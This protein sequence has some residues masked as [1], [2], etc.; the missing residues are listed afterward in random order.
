MSVRRPRSRAPG[1]FP[2]SRSDHGSGAIH[3]ALFLG[4]TPVVL[5]SIVLI[6]SLLAEDPTSVGPGLEQGPVVLQAPSVGGQPTPPEARDGASNLRQPAPPRPDPSWSLRVLD[7]AGAAIAGATV[8][9]IDRGEVKGR[10]TADDQ[11]WVRQA[12]ES[13]LG[14]SE[15]VLALAEGFAPGL[16]RGSGGGEALVLHRAAAIEVSVSSTAGAPIAGLPIAALQSRSGGLPS[17][18]YDHLA[19]NGIP[20]ELYDV[21]TLGAGPPALDQPGAEAALQELSRTLLAL[22]GTLGSVP[23]DSPLAWAL[24]RKT[25][26]AGVS[27]F[28][29][30][31]LGLNAPRSGVVRSASP[32]RTTRSCGTRKPCQHVVSGPPPSPP[33][34][35][36]APPPPPPAGELVG[37][38]PS[39]AALEGAAPSLCEREP[40]P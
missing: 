13:P 16:A 6:L 31:P 24:A 33:P 34:P 28:A 17:R 22:E 10:A 4:L 38:L 5:L 15:H 14:R 21:T 8:L 11:G 30:L 23:G 29:G 25:D 27:A 19:R 1:R 7:T 9:G 32:A 36:L 12:G 40:A 26:G 3:R 39:P 35:P 20:A 18:L 2:E 37:A